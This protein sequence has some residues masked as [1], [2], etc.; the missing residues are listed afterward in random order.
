M[1]RCSSEVSW[2]ES[3]FNLQLT[4]CVWYSHFF[5]KLVKKKTVFNSHLLIKPVY[6]FRAKS[7][8]T[9]FAADLD[10]VQTFRRSARVRL[11]LFFI[12][13]PSSLSKVVSVTGQTTVW[14]WHPAA[15]LLGFGAVKIFWESGSSFLQIHKQRECERED[16]EQLLLVQRMFDEC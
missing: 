15:G 13:L 10:L 4:K 11:V 2:F 16:A 12:R 1:I 3:A 14:P 7:S 8:S 5:W 9:W 6:Y